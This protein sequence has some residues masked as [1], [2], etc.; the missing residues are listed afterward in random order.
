MKTLTPE[1]LELLTSFIRI[2]E[3]IRQSSELVALGNLVSSKEKYAWNGPVPLTVLGLLGYFADA[4]VGDGS[5]LFPYSTDTS[6]YSA[7]GLAEACRTLEIR[8][9]KFY[10]RKD[11]DFDEERA[12]LPKE[13]RE[14]ILTR[15]C[16]QELGKSRQVGDVVSYKETRYQILSLEGPDCW[17]LLV[18]IGSVNFDK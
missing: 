14:I 10:P 5:H 12:R 7:F 2:Y 4:E 1:S 17:L 6:F 8:V 15:K 16:W 11:I 9:V 18:P 3:A 13:E